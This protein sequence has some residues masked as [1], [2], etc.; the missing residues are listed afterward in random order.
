[1]YQ[2]ELS[3]RE[4]SMIPGARVIHMGSM[5]ESCNV[6]TTPGCFSSNIHACMHKIGRAHV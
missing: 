6:T 2:L 4:Y 5:A 3:I 1:M